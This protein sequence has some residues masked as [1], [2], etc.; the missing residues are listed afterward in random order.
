MPR[1]VVPAAAVHDGRWSL[2]P[3]R[4]LRIVLDRPRFGSAIGFVGRLRR[5]P[6]SLGKC[7][8]SIGPI[9]YSQSIAV[10]MGMRQLQRKLAA[11]RILPLRDFLA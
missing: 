3:R 9:K 5:W 2:F 10:R 6:I 1:P 4:A 8:N 11:A 7:D